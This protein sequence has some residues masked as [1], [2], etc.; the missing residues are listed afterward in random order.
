MPALRRAARPAALTG[1][2]GI[3]RLKARGP[4]I[5]YRVMRQ[6]VCTLTEAEA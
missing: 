5:P 3:D 1:S 6:A 2:S 4:A